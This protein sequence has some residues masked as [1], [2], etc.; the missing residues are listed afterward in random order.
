MLRPCV[1]RL[2]PGQG[3]PA[4]GRR[5]MNGVTRIL[6]AVGL[7]AGCL[8]LVLELLGLESLSYTEALAAARNLAS[9]SF[10]TGPWR[11]LGWATLPAVGVALA[12]MLARLVARVAAKPPSLTFDS[13]QR[14]TVREAVAE[15]GRRVQECIA[16]G[17]ANV[18]PAFDEIV[19]GA[20]SLGASDIHISPTANGL[21]V[22]YRVDG[23]LYEVARLDLDHAP[24]LATRVKVLARL[25]TYVRG[26]PQDGRLSMQSGT[27]SVEARV[28][29]LPT[30]IG[31]RIVLRLVRTGSGTR[32]LGELGLP[33]HVRGGLVELLGKP[34]GL[35]FVTG[36]VG[37]GKT[38]TLYALLEHI[39]STRG[40]TTN[41]VTLEDPI[42]HELPFATQTQ[43]HPKAGLTFAGTLRS[44]LRQDPNVLMVGEIRDHET[45]EIAA[46]AAL[47]GHLILTSVHGES[48]TAP[49]ARLMEMRVEPFVL[50]S[51][52]LGC[53]SQR[54]VRTL[55]T[56]CR[57]PTTPEPMHVDRFAKL[58][59][60]LPPGRYFEPVG[61]PFCDE[62]GFLGRAPIAEL[63]TVTSALREAINQRANTKELYALAT[64]EGMTPLLRDGLNRALRGE[65]SLTEVLRVAG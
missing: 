42:E 48:A 40:R 50:A 58:G 64:A 41:L 5:S 17:R 2:L 13:L 32:R 3:R 10:S 43:M 19:R 21:R 24:R 14:G 61:C 27:T 18:I 25:D 57:R 34:E 44:V 37:S 59:I 39:A 52:T 29:T 51:G 11:W 60:V 12:A 45:A 56:G 49:F 30:E 26:V 47:T 65:T 35:W 62:Q 28:S 1:W 6:A 54:L 46:Q 31:E 16:G 22:T 38:T 63:L 4:P 36:P 7:G 8:G 9:A 20:V 23:T 15:V 33:E 55:C 53:M